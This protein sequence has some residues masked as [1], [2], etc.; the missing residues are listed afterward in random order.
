MYDL[1]Y[2]IIN[3]KKKFC[4]MILFLFKLLI[5]EI[6]MILFDRVIIFV[7]LMK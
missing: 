1:V 2:E 4:D 7:L 3:M 6:Y 5:N